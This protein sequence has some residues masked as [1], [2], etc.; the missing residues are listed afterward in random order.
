MK[1]PTFAGIALLALTAC[2]QDDGQSETPLADTAAT[3][4]SEPKIAPSVP[5]SVK[6]ADRAPADLSPYVGKYAF[7][8]VGGHRFLDNPAVKAAIAAAVP[9]AKQRTVVKFADDGLGLPIVKVDGGRILVWG[10]AKRAEDRNNWAVVIAPDGSKP[11]V[12]IYD[13]LGYGEEFQSAQWFKPGQPSIMKQG[14]C[15]STDEDYPAA[16]IAAG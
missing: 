6:E 15:P 16:E 4:K 2:G 5:V 12:C 3:A 9:D 8:E 1:I 11:E 7:D 10:G 13:G 14:T